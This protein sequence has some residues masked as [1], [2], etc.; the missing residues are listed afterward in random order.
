MDIYKRNNKIIIYEE[1][2]EVIFRDEFDIDVFDFESAKLKIN[3]AI[4]NYDNN[5]TDNENAEKEVPH[6][7]TIVKW[8]REYRNQLLT[9]SDWITLSDAPID[10]KTKRMWLQ[11]RQALRDIPN[12]WGLPSDDV[13]EIDTKQ[14]KIKIDNILRKEDIKNLP[15]PQLPEN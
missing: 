11:Y 10:E 13:F 4:E 1:H 15:F 7:Y 9:E 2:N 3:H 14:W 6:P 12:T 8:I 5:I